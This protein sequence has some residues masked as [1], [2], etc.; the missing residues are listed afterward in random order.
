MGNSRW[1]WAIPVKGSFDPKG[2]LFMVENSLLECKRIYLLNPHGCEPTEAR[3][4][5]PDTGR[6]PC[7]FPMRRN[8]MEAKHS[9]NSPEETGFW[10]YNVQSLSPFIMVPYDDA[11]NVLGWLVG[12]LVGF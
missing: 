12:R 3:H 10:I 9:K 4:L 2:L 5:K 11:Q 7:P 8:T 1:S 6:L